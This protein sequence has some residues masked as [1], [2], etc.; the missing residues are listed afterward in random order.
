LYQNGLQWKGLI[1]IYGPARREPTDRW[2]HY[3][4]IA[5][6]RRRRWSFFGNESARRETFS[7]CPLLPSPRSTTRRQ[8]SLDFAKSA[9][10]RA[11]LWTGDFHPP[12]THARTYSQSETARVLF[13]IKT[14][15]FSLSHTRTEKNTLTK[16]DFNCHVCVIHCFY[17]FTVFGIYL[18][19]SIMP[20]REAHYTPLSTRNFPFPTQRVLFPRDAP[21]RKRFPSRFSVLVRSGISKARPPL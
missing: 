11:R 10:A 9:R 7:Y 21:P 18:W 15:D 3:N 2:P 12:R 6:R 4:I 5:R 19:K 20:P 1:P 17:E 13:K 8:L 16:M 14:E